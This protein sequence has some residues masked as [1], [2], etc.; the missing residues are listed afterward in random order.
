MSHTV[1]PAH[2]IVRAI[3]LVAAIA[4]VTLGGL[5]LP[6]HAAPAA[7]T[8]LTASG[9]PIPTLAWDRVASATEYRVQGSTTSSFSS[10]IFNVETTNTRYTPVRVLPT[11]QLH[12]RVQTSDGTGT[13]GWS[14]AETTIGAQAVPTGVQVSPG[15]QVRPPASPP[16]IQW[17][18][19][20]GAIAYDVQMDADGSEVGSIQR[21]N[22]KST[23]YVWPDPQG[24][25]EREGD[26]DFFV[27]V[28]ARFDNAL[29]S[30]WSD[31]TSYDVTQLPYVTSTACA[32]GL[33][34][35]P[36]PVSGARPSTTVQDV[37]LDWDPVKGAKRYEIWVAVDRDFNTQVE[38]RIVVGTRYS[39]ATTYDNG[40]YFWKVRAY[41]A[42]DQPTPWPAT[43]SEFQRRWPQLPTLVYPPSSEVPVG[44]DV[45][46]QWTPVKHATRYTLEVGSD[47][48][49][50]TGSY[51][52]CTTASTTYTP[53]FERDKCMP[54]QGT[55]TY[56]RVRA[57]DAPRN[58]QVNGL[59]SDTGQFVYSSGRVMP[60]SPANNSLVTVPTFRWQPSPDANRYIIEL[61]GTAGSVAVTTAALS[62]TPTEL[63]PS[64]SDTV[65]PTR[66]PDVFTWQLTAID[67]DGKK[68]PTYVAGTVRVAESPIPAGASPLTPDPLAS[69]QISSRFPTLSW[70]P[71]A[72]T[73]DN[74]VYYKLRVSE[75]PGFMLPESATDILAT[76]L[77]YPAVTDLSTYFLRP[78]TRTWWIEAFDLKT[79]A[80]RG[81]GPT[82]T[83]T[84][85]APN[86]T[87]GQQV[88]LDG[89]AIDSADTCA[90]RLVVGDEQTVCTGMSATPVLD[91]ESVPGAGG[92]QVYVAEDPD[93][94]NIVY[95]GIQT[96]RSRWT[97][98]QDHA[99]ESLPDSE[100]GGAYYWYIR[101]CAQVFPTIN[102]GPG[103]SG[104]A[105]AGSSAFRK[106]SPRVEQMSPAAGATFA[107][108]VSFEWR[109]YHLTNQATTPPY[110]GSTAP[111]QTAM[112]YRIQVAQSATVT[113]SNRIDDQVVDQATYTPHA[114]TYPEGDLWWRVQAIDAAGNR[115][116]WSETRKLVKATPATNLDPGTAASPERPTVDPRAVPSFNSRTSAGSTVFQWTGQDFD[117]TWDLEVY[118]NDDTTGSAGNLVFKAVSKQA[119]F[120]S[121][122]PLAPSSEPYR[123]RIR[124]TDVDGE[125]GRWS[126]YG[127]FYVDA[128]PV[129]LT[130]P[131]Q[132]ASLAPNGAS[133][134]WAAYAAGGTQ[135][136]KYVVDVE[137]TSGGSNPGAVTTS[138]TAW[139]TTTDLSTGTY[140]WTVKAY[141][142]AGGL[143]GT[144][145]VGWFSIDAGL[146]AVT[147]TRIDAPTGSAVG[148][149]LTS[150]LP[151]WNQPDVQNTYQWL[152]NDKAIKDATGPT[153]VMT[154]LD[155]TKTITL[156][157]TGVR[158]GYVTGTSVSN[159]MGVAAGGALQNNGIPVVSGT[160]AVGE[161]LATTSGSWVPSASTFRYQ[162]TRNGAPIPGA[163]A[164]KYKVVAEDAGRAL[165]VI[166]FA[167]NTGFEEGAS[168]S[169][170]VTVAK[171]PSTTAISLKSTRVKPGK[172]VK[173][174][175]AV[176]VPGLTGPTG[177]VKIFDGAKALKS[178][179]LVSA[180]DG[181]LAWKLPKLK[182]G[183]HKIKAVYIGNDSAAGSKSKITK[184]FVVGSKK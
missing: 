14:T 34:C 101:P 114:L 168:A 77:A 116:A 104:T 78:G 81:S 131:P 174:G 126:D 64:D 44:D 7:P 19:V 3:A 37:T 8:G 112:R 45:Y 178:L 182:K 143:L 79:N 68:S 18:P 60:I 15:Q 100:S 46:Y 59:Y 124:R 69:G 173:I 140:S 162:W 146:S 99:P 89:R 53:G 118:R 166:V 5:T 121:P 87:T 83:F 35:A 71:V 108:E 134:T 65:D 98:A 181:K 149:T 165:A 1:Q 153:Y 111:H 183:K 106:V 63:L 170:P 163:T 9:V 43:P 130:S 52:T 157:V 159:A 103:P 95:N 136:T 26:E 129:S 151:A 133:F 97:P 29:Q 156:R 117:A 93:F 17:N 138:A 145:P 58:P 12:W 172:R 90:K 120:A 150:V 39:P 42:S 161:A 13:S 51:A 23:T 61:N 24:V 164:S 115:L 94:T 144:S 56:W 36:D 41:N 84:I 70:Q 20:A 123:W 160:A 175:I 31:W 158:P 139:A 137:P 179:T 135:A 25:G 154:V 72:S 2:R 74:P 57:H 142:T 6:A 30:D 148:Q 125:P 80:F 54:S 47:Q 92:Y 49:F 184:L 171:M 176:T 62:W 28:R 11:G 110:G 48:F 66:Q 177:V 127:R 50:S 102:C 155:Y 16:V 75:T 21:D 86:R 180:R 128:L 105:D 73:V 152:R 55:T 147:P 32:A 22:L 122:S 141:D 132:G 40:N 167:G 10:T 113:D 107:D 119:A 67:A 27:R 38:K 91:W 76:R 109:D 33:V 169:S 85:E 96:T 82:S 4:G 88:A